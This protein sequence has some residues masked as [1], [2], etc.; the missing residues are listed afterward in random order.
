MAALCC[1]ATGCSDDG[2]VYERYVAIGDSYTAGP[3][4]PD[5]ETDNG[6]GRSTNSYPYQVARAL[7][8]TELVDIACG[9][10]TTANAS[11]PQRNAY[12]HNLAQLKAV[13]EDADLVTVSLGANDERLF[14]RLVNACAA[15][16]RRTQ[17]G[18]PCAEASSVGGQDALIASATRTR[19]RLAQLLRAVRAKAPHARVLAVGYPQLARAGES[20]PQRVPW[21]PGDHAYVA[22]VLDALNAAVRAAA[23]DAGV[24]YVDIAALSAGHSVCDR[25]PWVA[26]QVGD[27]LVAAAAH[28]YLREQ[29]AVARAVVAQASRPAG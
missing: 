19:G 7:R 25:R 26:G 28:P 11:V 9:G 21:A 15:A 6:C 14:G 18:S 27:P 1:V 29:T 2:P 16:G 12:G 10:A 4:I 22:R 24:E 23:T 8:V 20:C 3:S 17:V 5:S 13:D